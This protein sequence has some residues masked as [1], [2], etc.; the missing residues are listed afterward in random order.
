MSEIDK[1][2]DMDR[3]QRVTSETLYCD[4]LSIPFKW[5]FDYLD[6]HYPRR[7]EHPGYNALTQM[8]YDFCKENLDKDS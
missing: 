7:T 6:R 1:Q 8:F 4:G 2:L 5:F 3:A